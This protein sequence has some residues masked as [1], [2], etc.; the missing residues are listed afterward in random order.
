MDTIGIAARHSTPAYT[1]SPPIS[2]RAATEMYTSFRN[3]VGLSVKAG[4]L[5]R[6]EGVRR[7]IVIQAKPGNNCHSDPHLPTTLKHRSVRL[8]RH[9]HCTAISVM[10]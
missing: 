3:V 9:Y 4:D 8:L 6:S 2:V 7:E 10:Q 5:R 1:V